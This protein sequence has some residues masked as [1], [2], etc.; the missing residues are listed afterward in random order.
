MPHED[1]LKD[2]QRHVA[3]EVGSWKRQQSSRKEGGNPLLNAAKQFTCQ[4]WPRLTL[5][6]KNK[7]TNFFKTASG[8][9]ALNR[10]KIQP[11]TWSTTPRGEP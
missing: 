7:N 4:G 3:I 2:F 1:F 10:K 8:S 11:A 9:N 5:L 6:L